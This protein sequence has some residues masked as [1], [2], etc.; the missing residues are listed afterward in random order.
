MRMNKILWGLTWISILFIG[1][2]G[3]EKNVVKLTSD[4]EFIYP[5]LPIQQQSYL[6]ENVESIDYI[7]QDLP[8]SLSQSEKPSIQTKIAGIS[9]NGVKANGCSP[10]ARMFFQIK[11]EILFEADVY[12]TPPD[13]HYYVFLENGKALY[14]NQMGE[15]NINFYL[16][17]L[18]Q[19]N[20]T[21]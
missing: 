4:N 2:K 9:Q 16:Q 12:F 15:Q 11:G 13:C 14:A 21:Q 1:C 6:F 19:M 18:K 3:Q 10:I 8:F 5:V 20:V 7:F 17:F